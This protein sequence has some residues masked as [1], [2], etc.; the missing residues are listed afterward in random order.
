MARTQ[1]WMIQNIADPSRYWRHSRHGSEA[2]FL[3][4]SVAESWRIKCAESK[5]R[6][7]RSEWKVVKMV[8]E[9]KPSRQQGE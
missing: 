1:R 8:P 2:V 6:K 7:R 5:P 9:V 3:Y 4:E